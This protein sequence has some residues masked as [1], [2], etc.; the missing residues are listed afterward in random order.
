VDAARMVR[1]YDSISICLSKGLGAPVGSVLVGSSK[2]IARAH[3]WRKMFGGGMRQVGLIAAGGL[4]AINNHIQ[5]LADDH[6]RARQLA[7][8][9]SVMDGFTVDI[10]TI[11]TNMVYVKGLIEGQ[12]I[13]DQLAVHGVDVLTV[14]QNM[15]RAVTHLHITDEDIEQAIAAFEKIAA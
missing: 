6:L 7:E 8:A 15:I 5:R 10:D 2:L 11:E 13:V 1:D 3:R 14:G 4:H 9:V 12:D